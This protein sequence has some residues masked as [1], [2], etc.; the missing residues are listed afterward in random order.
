MNVDLRLIW[1]KLRRIDY[2]VLRNYKSLDSEVESGG[3]I[4]ILCDSRDEIIDILKLEPRFSADNLYNCKMIIENQ[5]IPID[6]R[7][8]GD[9][10]YDNRW[11]MEMLSSKKRYKDFYVMDEEDEKYSLLYHILLHKKDI[12]V[13]YEKFLYES[14]GGIDK[15][16]LINELAEYMKGKKYQPVIPKDKGVCFNSEIFDE[17]KQR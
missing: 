13:K 15:M 17:L 3:D 7:Y 10:Y 16:R 5:I 12:P 1:D 2:L 9:G 8:V 4:D 14:F 6:V 11:E